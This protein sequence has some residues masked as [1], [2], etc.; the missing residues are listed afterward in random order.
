MRPID[1]REVRMDHWLERLWISEEGAEKPA[2][3]HSGD[4]AAAPLLAEME[5]AGLV[6]LDGGAA[7]LTASGR[8]RAEILIRRRRLAERLLLDVLSIREEEATHQACHFEHILSPEVTETVCTFLG[9]P[10]TCPHG[11]PI[12]RGVC[13]ARSAGERM[14]PLV[15]RLTEMGPGQEGRVSFI[16]PRLAR[17]LSRLATLGVMPGAVLRLRQKNPSFVIEIGETSVALDAE[18]AGEI[19]V[20]PL[21]SG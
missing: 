18:I 9:H 14:R 11:R 6:R 19:F 8:A 1:A 7:A 15:V 16:A 10:P 2:R 4:A 12:P 21:V 5:K 17:R 13:C 3:G 20:R